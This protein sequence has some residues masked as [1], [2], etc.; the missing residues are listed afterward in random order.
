MNKRKE[1]KEKKL[2]IYALYIVLFNRIKSLIK[3]IFSV[4]N[5]YIEHLIVFNLM[6]IKILNILYIFI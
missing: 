4:K 3:I 6:A 1:D 5:N 2:F